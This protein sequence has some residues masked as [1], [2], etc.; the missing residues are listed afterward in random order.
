EQV[1]Y[2]R[3]LLLLDSSLATSD[4]LRQ[5]AVVRRLASQPGI[6]CIERLQDPYQAMLEQQL[7]HFYQQRQS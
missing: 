4:M 6:Y 5:R 2:S 7:N 1:Q 3:N